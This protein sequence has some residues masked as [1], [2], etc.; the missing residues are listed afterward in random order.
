MGNAS[1]KESLKDP[2]IAEAIKLFKE[3]NFEQTVPLCQRYI[4]SHAHE[5]IEI[6]GLG[7]NELSI[8][9]YEWFIP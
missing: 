3:K 8:G 9:Y 1:F 4:E 2:L 5:N 7:N 6:D